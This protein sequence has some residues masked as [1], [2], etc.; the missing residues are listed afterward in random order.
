MGVG[1][2][3]K[4]CFPSLPSLYL[5]MATRSSR[6]LLPSLPSSYSLSLI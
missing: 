6:T 5:A 4:K 1:L 3:V 2:T